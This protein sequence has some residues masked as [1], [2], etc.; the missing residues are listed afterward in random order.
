MTWPANSY[1]REL[2]QN[3][4]ARYAVVRYDQLADRWLI[5]MPIFRRLPPKDAEPPAPTAGEAAHWSLPSV[6]NQPGPAEP[7]FQPPL[8]VP[9]RCLTRVW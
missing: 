1:K 9:L 4:M 8:S 7:L 6:A 2:Q 3:R 5:V